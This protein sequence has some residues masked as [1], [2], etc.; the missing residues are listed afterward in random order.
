MASIDEKLDKIYTLVHRSNEGLKVELNQLKVTV[1][2]EISS[3]ACSTH[4]E[5][6]KGMQMISNIRHKSVNRRFALVW[7]VLSLI[8]GAIITL[9]VLG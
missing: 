6:M 4:M 2:K 3:L 5:K 7:S 9:K 1:T 8:F